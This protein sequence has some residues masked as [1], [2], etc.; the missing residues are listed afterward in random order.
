MWHIYIVAVLTAKKGYPPP[1]TS[2]C[3]GKVVAWRQPSAPSRAAGAAFPR[4]ARVDLYLCLM[5]VLDSDEGKDE[6]QADEHIKIAKKDVAAV[7][8][9]GS[10][11]ALAG[12]L[13]YNHEAVTPVVRPVI[14][15]LT[16]IKH[17]RPTGMLEFAKS[18]DI[19]LMVAL[20][21]W[22]LG[23][24]VHISWRAGRM[25][26]LISKRKLELIE[27][28]AAG[29]GAAAAAPSAAANATRRRGSDPEAV[30]PKTPVAHRIDVY[31][32]Q[33]AELS[34]QATQNAWLTTIQLL[35]LVGAYV[36]FSCLLMFETHF[37]S[38]SM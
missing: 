6:D 21:A 14:E 31:N 11:T 20:L 7:G 19:A 22:G 2:I 13:V 24:F 4:A 38:P 25:I 27:L 5:G 15:M 23:T 37:A 35:V 29:A 8:M 26:A 9:Y 28:D 10:L 1:G 12:G 3:K 18:V 34:K 17:V 36:V 32:R 30:A 33:E 16:S